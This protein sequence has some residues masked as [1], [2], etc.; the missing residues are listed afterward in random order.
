MDFNEYQKEARKTVIYP[1]TMKV[2]YPS[3]GLAG[4]CGE[5]CDKV[6]KVYRD[7]FGRV[8][9]DDREALSKELGDV[10]WYVANLASDLEL[11][12]QSIAF[13]NLIKLRDRQERGKL[14]GDGDDR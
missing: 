7:K 4:E 13:N 10:L 12:L 2:T 6:K 11:P 5:V 9:I 3:L 8:G 14:Q 1:H